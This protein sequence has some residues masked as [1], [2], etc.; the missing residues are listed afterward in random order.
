MVVVRGATLCAVILGGVAI[1]MFTISGCS[2][3]EVPP[4]SATSL[5]SVPA[6]PGKNQPA[7]FVMPDLRGMFWFDAGQQLQTL[8]WSGSLLKGPDVRDSG[9]GPGLIVTQ[10]PEPGERVALRGMI[11]LRFAGPD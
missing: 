10:D 5:P 4:R 6:E 2:H 9:Y 1:G 11:T 7:S 8:G 3:S